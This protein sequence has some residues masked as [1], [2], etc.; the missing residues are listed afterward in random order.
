MAAPA[1]HSTSQSYPAPFSQES[2]GS[3]M[4]GA[5]SAQ[6]HMTTFDPSQST[7]STPTPTPPASRGNH[8]IAPFNNA[9]YPPPNGV[10]IQQA[11]MRVYNESNG[12]IPQQQYPPGHKPQ[13]YTVYEMEVNG[14]AAMRRR[15][16]SWLNATQILKIAGIDKG[17][18]T[19]VLEKEILCGE[20][21]KVQG[22]Y[23]KYQGTWINYQRGVEFCRQY[24]VAEILRP[25][26]EYDMGQDGLTTAG[27]GN[28]ETPTKEQAMAA[29]RK[30]NMLNGS[31]DSRPSPQS[32]NGTFFQNISK[33]AAHAVNAIN[34]A[35]FDSPGPKNASG[36]RPPATGRRPS[37]HVM[38][39]QESAFHGS[40]QQ[41]M[42]SM[43]SNDTFLSST[44]LDPALRAQDGPFFNT[45]P[46]DDA[47][48]PPRKRHRP[49]SS[50]DQLGYNGALG[51]DSSMMD[52]DRL[53][54]SSFLYPNSQSS[55]PIN[56]TGLKPLPQ[57]SSNSAIEKQQILTSL[58]LDPSQTDFTN[59]PAFLRLSNDDLDVPID[60]TAHTALHWAATLARTSL[61]RA[62]ISKG[63]SI[64]RLNGGG[65]TALIRA[66]L[67]TNNL[68]K[69]TFPELLELLGST[70][71]IRD[72]RGRTVLHHIATSSA[73]Q[74]RGPACRY[75]LESLLEYVVRQGSAS[76]S[77]QSSFHAG[78]AVAT[79]TP[80]T[81]PIGLAKF[82]SEIVNAAD[83]SGD[84]ALNLAARIGN[85]SIIQQL[86]EVGANPTIANRGGLKPVD[87]GVGG[88]PEPI[89]LAPDSSQ[90][91]KADKSPVSRV[92]ESSQE[93]MSSITN[94]ISTTESSFKSELQSKQS[95]IDQTH[96]KL[97]ETTSL[98][99]EE[100]RRLQDLQRQANA[101]KALRTK[102]ANLKHANEQLRAK[103]ST[104]GPN[105]TRIDPKTNIKTGEADAGLEVDVSLLPAQELYPSPLDPD[106]KEAR[107]LSSLPPTDVLRARLEAYKANNARLDAEVKNLENQ[108]SELEGQLRRVVALCT[109][110]DEDKVDEMVGGL[111]A[112][113]E[114]ERG[115][116]VEV[117]RLND[118][119]R[120]VDADRLGRS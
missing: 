74:G 91:T 88:D 108:S 76:S 48:E 12:N 79:M 72:G 8:H 67:T 14:V 95:L 45:G 41:S 46:N 86:L 110:V 80:A 62:L 120:R 55:L 20:H 85:K 73:I 97:R 109:Q 115:E 102:T 104:P 66:A 3:S 56:L 34:R 117:G 78:A 63:A 39:S 112:A 114:S 31:F 105:G 93:L 5:R 90:V 83:I 54:P 70:I 94:L 32:Q 118:F 9:N 22:G 106:S 7:T 51:R 89:E 75:Y 26:L 30:K 77:Q 119:L 111:V 98:L 50:Q 65:E 101:R 40:S 18:R 24:G 28:I 103:L 69:G 21:E 1:I 52:L 15:V 113:V 36:S 10:N 42:Q 37:Q 107:Y 25:L 33:T 84:T 96:L 87:F 59:H 99:A 71:E 17:K 44:P 61:V 57:P 23:G 100:R 6:G 29:L 68:D 27:H 43:Q 4:N 60:A 11:P 16:D 49:S 19:K 35:R 64:F 81:K 53:E 2:A 58:F 92:T 13:I 38:G 82:M 116:D 47:N